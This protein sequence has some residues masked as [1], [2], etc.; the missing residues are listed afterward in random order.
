MC[1]KYF[2]TEKV[3][4]L[5]KDALDIISYSIHSSLPYENTKRILSSVD[6]SCK[7]LFVL[8]VGKA[9]VP[10]AKAAD[11][12]LGSRISN[13]LVV[14]KYGHVKNFYSPYFKI[15]EASHPIGDGN[16]IKAAEQALSAVASLKEKDI[17]LVLLSG[18]G[19]ALFEKS[20][21]PQDEYNEINRKLLSRGADISEINAVRRRLSIVKGGRFAAAA[22]PAKVITVA[23]SD[24]LTNDKKVIASGITV[25]D[26]TEGSF[27]KSTID[28]YLYDVKD[29]I[30]SLLY[31]EHKIKI[32][33]G[34]YYFAGDINMLCNA[35]FEKARSL[36]Y[37]AEIIDNSVTGEA[38]E[39]A[40]EMIDCIPYKYGKHC[41]IFGGET[42]VTL[43]GHG[44]GGRN[45]EMALAAAIKIKNRK[46]IV[47]ASA[48][49]DGTD[50][51]TDDAGGIVDGN[52]YY[53]MK[54]CGVN[55]ESELI[56]NNSNYA[57]G[58]ADAIITTGPTGTNVNDLTLIMTDFKGEK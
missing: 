18:G 33:D 4:M 20:L 58:C 6:L 56:N 22:Y 32:N 21:L 45:Q 10:M 25:K 7:D 34:G 13:G 30:K 52:T 35:A 39:K 1:K 11:N 48:G 42:T 26:D 12:I 44:I 3:I 5:K 38:K 51:P 9:A 43:K 16:S 37:E 36:G 14:T 55:P 49:S 46:D 47:F 29:E 54:D 8:S 27:I 57:L 41:Y 2:H 28:K 17:C 40:L 24:V 19:S 15:I 23:L 53:E 50:G 31:E